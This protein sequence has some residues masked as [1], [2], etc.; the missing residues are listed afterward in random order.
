MFLSLEISYILIE[1]QID[2]CWSQPQIYSETVSVLFF[3]SRLV[4]FIIKAIFQEKKFQLISTKSYVVSGTSSLYL[5]L[6]T[7][8]PR[9][10]SYLFLTYLSRVNTCRHANILFSF[11][12]P[13]QIVTNYTH[14]FVSCFLSFYVYFRK[15]SMGI[16]LYQSHVFKIFIV[17]V[18][19]VDG[20]IYL[21]NLLMIGINCLQI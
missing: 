15:H 9:T 2:Q 19:A 18:Q 5:I 1:R 12:F 8:F 17:V 7:R 16:C 11:S 10:A 21:I 20:I 14:N 4:F 3:S 6:C 13:P